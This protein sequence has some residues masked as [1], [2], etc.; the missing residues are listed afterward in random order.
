MNLLFF[1]TIR[2]K[3]LLS[4][5]VL[6]LST[7]P[8]ISLCE[9]M[10]KRYW[11]DVRFFPELNIF[12]PY[13]VSWCEFLELMNNSLCRAA[14]EKKGTRLAFKEKVQEEFWLLGL[15]EESAISDSENNQKA[16]VLLVC[17]HTGNDIFDIW[18]YYI[19]YYSSMYL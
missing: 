2:G 12:S 11:I 16:M 8:Y 14:E 7:I 5:G 4:L 10:R 1:Q 13:L 3:I 18:N 15:R 6:V 9:P 17:H 19:R